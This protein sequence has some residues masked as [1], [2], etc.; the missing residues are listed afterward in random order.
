MLRL[1]VKLLFAS[2]FLSSVL[3]FAGCGDQPKAAERPNSP[4]KAADETS[5]AG[6]NA[7]A[8]SSPAAAK[9]P[10]AAPAVLEGVRQFAQVLDLGKLPVPTGGTLGES[11]P[12]R[13]HAS[14]PLAVPAA[15]DFYAGKLDTLGWKRAGPKTM[16]AVTDSFAQL[17]LGKVGYLLTM[18]V[19]PS[20]PKISSVEIEQH[21]D[22]DA[23][24]LLRLEGAEDQYSDHGSSLYFTTVKFDKAVDEMRRRLKAA[25]WQEY[26]R[27]FSQKAD[28][29]D[30]ADLLFRKKAYSLG[31]SISIPPADPGKTAVQCH[32]TTLARDMPAPADAGHVEIADSRWIMM[33]DTPGDMAA[34]AEYYRKAM[35]EVGFPDAPKENSSDNWRTLSFESPDHNLVLITLQPAKEKNAKEKNAKEKD[36]KVQGTKV[37]LEGYSAAFLEAQKKAATAAK[38]KRLAQEKADIEAKLARA[39]AVIG[40][41]QDESIDSVLEKAEKDLKQAQPND[42][43][44]KK[45]QDELDAKM[46]EL[47]DAKSRDSSTGGRLGK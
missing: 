8:A 35:K 16:E 29:R 19:V 39:K 31:V 30:A 45:I 20:D 38:L 5:P 43:N 26:D 37:K 44:I 46:K 2:G 23:R 1:T 4:N 21:G 40:A 33:C 10:P 15:V 24:T 13:F 25:G 36:A 14:V 9:A 22:L 42:G 47:Q 6:K 41:R 34:A 28:R 12:T 32:V 17:Q 7:E 27:A 11:S 18:T 3:L